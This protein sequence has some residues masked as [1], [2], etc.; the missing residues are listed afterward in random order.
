MWNLVV[1]KPENHNLR[2]KTTMTIEFEFNKKKK[3]SLV[4]D[5]KLQVD[6]IRRKVKTKAII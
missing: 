5:T 1:S 4:H 6:Q 3:R 2:C